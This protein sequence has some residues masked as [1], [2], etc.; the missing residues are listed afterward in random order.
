MSH[1]D[2]ILHA[3]N[4][5]QRKW[6]YLEPIFG[7]GSL[8]NEAKR[9]KSVDEDFRDIM[10]NA[11]ADPKLFGLVDPHVHRDIRR[12]L[13]TMLD[14]LDRCQ[15]ALSDFLEEKRSRAGEADFEA[16]PSQLETYTGQDLS[17]MP[18]TQLKV[19]ALVMDL[20]H[21]MDVLDQL[22]RARCRD[23]H[24]WAWHK[25]L[26]YYVGGGGAEVRMS[27]G[28]FRYTY[29]YQGNAGKLVHTPLTDKCYLTLT[30]GMHMGFG[31]NPYGPAGTGKTESVKA[32]GNAFGRQ[33]LVFNC[34]EGADPA[35]TPRIDF[36]S[37]GRIFIGLV[38]CGAWGCFDEFNR[39]K[40]DQLS[41]I[42]QQIQLIQDAIKGHIPV[43]RLLGRDVDVDFDAGIFVTLNPAGKDYGGRSQI[44]DNLKALFRPVAMGRP[45]NELIAQV[46]LQAE[47]FTRARDLAVKVVSLFALSR[48]LLTP[49]RHYD[50]GLRALKAVLNTGG[51][52]VLD[53]R[54]AGGGLPPAAEGELLIKAV[55]VNT[56]SKL[57]FGDT[58]RF[59]ALI[60][61]V[62]PGVASGDV[63][64]GALEVAIRDVMASGVPPHRRRGPGRKML[65]LK[66][67]LDQRM[68][69]VVVGP[70]G[71][72]KSTVWRARAGAATDRR[73]SRRTSRA[74]RRRAGGRAL[75][76]R[77]TAGA[78]SVADAVRTRA[79]RRRAGRP[80][81]AQVMNPKSMPRQQLL[82][83]MDLD[84]REW[85][86]GVLT[87]AARAVVREPPE[88]RSWIVCDGDVDP[89]WI[90]S[91]NSVLDDNHLLTLPNG[92]RI[93]F[94]DNVN[95]LFETH[96][97]RFASPA[98]VSRMGMI[99]LSDEDI[100]TRRVVTRW[101]LGQ[102]ADLRP[103]LE[104]WLD[105]LFYRALDYVV[106]LGAF[107]VETTLVGTV[108]NG[109]GGRTM[110]MLRPMVE[111][112]APFVVVGP[113][114]CGKNLM[115]RHAFAARRKVG[116]ATLH[117]SARTDASHVIAKIGQCCSLFS[118]PEGRV[119]RPRDCERLVLYLKDLNLPRPDA[120]DTCMLIAFLQQ[121]VTFR[122]FY[123]ASL[124][125]L[126][127]EHV[128]I[129]ASMNPATTVGRH[130]LSTRF[131]ATVRVCVLDY[132][133][134]AELTAVYAE[135]LEI[136]LDAA[137]ARGG[138]A[139][140]R[141]SRPSP[142]PASAR[143]S[144]RRSSRSTS[145][146]RRPSSSTTR[147][148]TSSRRATSAWVSNLLA[149][150][151]EDLLNVVAYEG[152]RLFKDRMVDADAEAKLDGILGGVLRSRWRFVPA[153]RRP[154]HDAARGAIGAKGGGGGGAAPL[155][156]RVETAEFR[157]VVGKGVD[158]YE[159]ERSSAC[160]SS[161]AC[162]T[163]SR[164]D[165]RGPGLFG[166]DELEGLFA[167]LR[168]PMADEGTALSPYEFFVARVRA[169][170]HVCVAMDPTNDA[171][172][173]R[174]ADEA[175]LVEAQKG[176][177]AAMEMIT[178]TLSEA[179]GRRGEVNDLKTEI[180]AEHL[181]EIR[182][183]K[184]PPEPIAD[185]LGAVLKLLGISDVS[186]TSMKKFL[187]NRGVK[188]EILNYDARR[189]GGEMRKDVARLLKQKS[190]SFDQATIT[191]VS[192]AAAPLAAWVKAN[193]RYS[194]CEGEIAT[195]D[196]ASALKA[197]F[198]DKTRE[199]EKLRARLALAEGTLDKAQHLLGKLSGEQARRCPEDAR[200]A[201]LA[202]WTATVGLAAFD[203]TSLLATESRLLAW[204]QVGLPADPLS[205]ENALV[206]AH[207]P[208]A[209]VPFV[210]DP[211]TP[212]A[213]LVA[214]WRRRR[215]ALEV[216]QSADARF[217][218]TVELAVR[219]GKTLLIFDVGAAAPRRPARRRRGRRRATPPRGPSRPQPP[220]APQA[221][222]RA[223]P[224][225]RRDLAMNGPAP[226]SASAT[227]PS[228]STNFRLALVTRNPTPDLPPDAAA[229]CTLVNF[230]V[231][232][233]GLEG[234]LGATIQHEEPEL[235]A[236]KTAMLKQ[237][238]DYKIK[239]AGLETDLLEALATA[240]G[241]LL[242]NAL[243]I[244]S[245]TR[246]K[247]ASR[248]ISDA[249]AAS[250]EAS[251]TLDAR[252][253]AYR[254]FSRDG[255]RLYFLVRDLVLVN[256]MYQVSLASF[257]RLFEAALR[258]GSVAA[259]GA[260]DDRLARLTPLLE[261][262]AFFFVG[263][264]L[265]KADRCMFALHVVHGM[266]AEHFLDHEWEL[267]TGELAAD[268]AGDA[269][270]D[271]AGG[272]RGRGDGDGDGAGRRAS[273][274]ADPSKE[275]AD[276]AASVVGAD[277]YTSLAMGGGTHDL[278][279]SLL[280][281]ASAAGTWLC[282]QN[283]HLVVA[284]LP[285]LE[286][287][288]AGVFHAILQERRTYIPQGWTKSYEFSVG[289]LRAGAFDAIYGGRVDNPYDAR[290]LKAYLRKIF[291]QDVFDGRGDLMR[292][293]SIPRP[294]AFDD[295][296][297]AVA[298]LPDGDAPALFGL[299]D[300]IERS[301]QR[302]QSAHAADQLRARG[303]A[304]ATEAPAGAVDPI[305]GF[306]A[307]ERAIAAAIT[308]E[309]AA[310]PT[311]RKVVYGTALLTPHIQAVVAR[312]EQT[313]RLL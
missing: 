201:A 212:R 270:P 149:D 66:E 311:L 138:D 198:G 151:G 246:T 273:R 158:Y 12:T 166:A 267:F 225:A 247:E 42:S 87:D 161:T 162:S 36:Q 144:P 48:Q 243:L 41:A 245:L 143:S 171:F 94:G 57:T 141:T 30:Q 132:P 56:L 211:R 136:A 165:A 43:L 29:E 224:L 75:A 236:K 216:L 78:L 38:K 313:C 137:G 304:K 134:T 107:V 218:T 4:G 23:A 195:I 260:L 196:D 154:L 265:F 205:M 72:G 305:A 123:D 200:E 8:P 125:F 206:V 299:P 290:V 140:T 61:D 268:G 111:G 1:L 197:E 119:Y 153:R 3:L 276:F 191:R 306:V 46:Y 181:N 199:A 13:E 189:I 244:E 16:Y 81:P 209:R 302:T 214:H 233:S 286:K 300:N 272:R 221:R 204:K 307:M 227:A 240:E 215:P 40:E 25:Q 155:L 173:A 174:G 32:L 39:L 180:K 207:N 59:L 44:P 49:Q 296:L 280:A 133:D 64:G 62:F 5:I 60:G 208:G 69:C 109:L 289:D 63:A 34:D 308:A 150:R 294:C 278:A 135:L 91:L 68:G 131:T 101:L 179:T 7:R 169:R 108:L 241:D 90:E 6:V 17:G 95:F 84:T 177:D 251:A 9:F 257:V 11:E 259:D 163:T 89:E 115:I 157:A 186:W 128:Q 298:A 37:M 99:F 263:R 76:E 258:D 156:R 277:R 52:L 139:A 283:L 130:P 110:A 82:G 288:L 213:W 202:D 33:V 118:A 234:Q 15:K 117:C 255:S 148:T 312:A 175:K 172:A 51:K 45:D 26:R 190:T 58:A 293:L 275:L 35:S 188:D 282:F 152:L 253:E 170:L 309:V 122:G 261:R 10:R 79:R 279:M 28:S 250:A 295:A 249:L 2:F 287:A 112:G 50:W 102:D 67:A 126:R 83:E 31:G 187:G 116:V 271:A 103:R 105:D 55:R 159:R 264:G 194:V 176:A 77:A 285:A 86:D 129:V 256:P 193:I 21:N 104:G 183:L 229:L 113:E 284:W 185:V 121:L 93:A 18:V 262:L 27:D 231:T 226:S 242:E 22:D 184:M 142:S 235:E 291:N 106:A 269:P 164:V 47:G 146:S 228:T 238:E 20:V 114:G 239:L 252:R 254:G 266:H 301:V 96:D 80:G 297:A 219:F 124:E 19:K 274:R 73:A 237:E 24:D 70:S 120:Y 310:T 145:A 292:G 281:D 127:L 88:V 85:S 303:G 220:R 100:D 232:R 74:W 222:A 192:V 53:A 203:F 248:E 167:Q 71:C 217:G 92:E 230:T 182:S 65:Q 147:A 223:L 178:K 97:L 14:Q 54:G 168:E 98:T 210:I 160:S